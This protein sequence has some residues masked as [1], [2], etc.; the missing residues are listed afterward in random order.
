MPYL[1]DERLQEAERL[2][3]QAAMNFDRMATWVVQMADALKGSS[4][5]DDPRIKGTLLDDRQWRETAKYINE[6]MAE[7]R[8]FLEAK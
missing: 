8:S 7:I 1:V 5:K 2:L 3:R 4:F 6:D